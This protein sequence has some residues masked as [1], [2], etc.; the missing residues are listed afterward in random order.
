[1]K[2]CVARTTLLCY[3]HFHSY[4]LTRI[5]AFAGCQ[6]WNTVNE[7]FVEAGL[8]L[9]SYL[10]MFSSCNFLQHI[11]YKEIKV[12]K[13][14]RWKKVRGK[15]K[16]MLVFIHKLH[17]TSCSVTEP[18]Q[19]CW[20]WIQFLFLWVGGWLLTQRIFSFAKKKK[21]SVHNTRAGALGRDYFLR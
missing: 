5:Q 1:M 2:G 7:R 19:F 17:A 11:K 6:T 14:K 21:S 9:T 20:N 13:G 3:K 4:I 12:E 18:T 16:E 10:T 15:G 8:I